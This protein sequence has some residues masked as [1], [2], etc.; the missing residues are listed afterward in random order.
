MG[1]SDKFVDKFVVFGLVPVNWPRFESRILS[2]HHDSFRLVLWT[3]R[4]FGA[5]VK[6]GKDLIFR[7]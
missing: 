7:A 2:E 3:S 5:M 4:I 6:R 1:F